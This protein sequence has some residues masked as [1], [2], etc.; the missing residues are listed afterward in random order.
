[1]LPAICQLYASVTGEGHVCA[2]SSGIMYTQVWYEIYTISYTSTLIN[3][4]SDSDLCSIEKSPNIGIEKQKLCCLGAQTKIFCKI[5]CL[6]EPLAAK[7]RPSSMC[8]WQKPE[9][10]ELD[11]QFFQVSPHLTAPDASP[12]HKFPIWLRPRRWSKIVPKSKS[13]HQKFCHV[14]LYCM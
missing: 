5:Q 11:R 4:T 2:P 6:I 7:T 14:N 13:P 10:P 3:F 1:M 8:G 9:Y 12:W